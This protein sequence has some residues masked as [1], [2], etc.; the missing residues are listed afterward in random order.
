MSQMLWGGSIKSLIL[1]Q[2][3]MLLLKHYVI[4]EHSNYMFGLMLRLWTGYVVQNTQSKLNMCTEISKLKIEVMGN[5]VLKLTIQGWWKL[6]FLSFF[7]ILIS[8]NLL[9]A[10][11]EDHCFTSSNTTLTTARHH[12]PEG[13]RT[14]NPRSPL[15]ANPHLW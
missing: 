7:R 11:A 12:V 3:K 4:L 13:I 1:F 15:A 9:I 6:Y 2:S 14:R 5:I 8:F 10:G